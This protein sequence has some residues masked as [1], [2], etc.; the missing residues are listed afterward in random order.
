MLIRFVS[1]ITLTALEKIYGKGLGEAGLGSKRRLVRKKGQSGLC[2]R[3]GGESIALTTGELTELS[4]PSHHA[5]RRSGRRLA[6]VDVAPARRALR[7]ACAPHWNSSG[8]SWSE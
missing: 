5:G 1:K 3:G 7:R 2:S 8:G 6:A 4:T